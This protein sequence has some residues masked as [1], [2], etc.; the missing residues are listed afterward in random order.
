MYYFL[1]VDS[2][3]APSSFPADSHMI[4]TATGVKQTLLMMIHINILWLW[5]RRSSI[6]KCDPIAFTQN[7]VQF[8]T[9][10]TV[11]SNHLVRP[12]F[13]GGSNWHVVSHSFD[14]GMTHYSR[15]SWYLHCTTYFTGLMS[16]LEMERILLL[17]YCVL[18]TVCFLSLDTSS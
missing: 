13:A 11:S 3:D 17:C 16:L 18:S 10:L 1:T 8:N 14:S 2:N 15:Q 6:I 5:L 7:T 9:V 4:Q 12:L